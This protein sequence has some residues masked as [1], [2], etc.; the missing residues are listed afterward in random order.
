MGRKILLV[1]DDRHWRHLA[2]LSLREAGHDVVEASDAAE[3]LLQKDAGLAAIVLDLDLG[4]ENGLMLMQHLKRN[5]PGVP[6]ILFT[7]IE[8]DEAAVQRM[9]QNG[10][11]L[12]VRK[13][14]VAELLKAVSSAVK[15]QP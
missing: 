9:L 7:G 4:G 10:A 8:H 11:S 2:G 3:A 12:Y 15:P 14:A 1:E 13:G 5:H 6:I